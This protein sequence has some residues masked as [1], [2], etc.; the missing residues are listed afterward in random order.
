MYGRLARF[1]KKA[2]TTVKLPYITFNP[3]ILK[4]LVSSKEFGTSN[5]LVGVFV[6][7]G[8]KNCAIRIA[9]YD[10]DTG[11]K[12]TRLQLN[13][14]FTHESLTTEFVTTGYGIDT[15]YYTNVSK[16][17][18]E[19]SELFRWAHYIVIESQLP[20]NYDL[21]RM[22]Q[23]ITTYLMMTV[24]DKGFRPLII[25]IDPKLKSR[26]LGAPPKMTKPQLKVWCKNKA[27][28]ILR[29]RGDTVTADMIEKVRKGDDH[30][31]TV[32]YEEIWWMILRD[33]L[34]TPPIPQDIHLKSTKL[35]EGGTHNVGPQLLAT[36]MEL[37]DPARP[38]GSTDPIALATARLSSI[39]F[40]APDKKPSRLHIQ[41]D[42]PLP[43]VEIV[44]IVRRS[45]LLIQTTSDP[46]CPN[47]NNIPL[48]GSI[49]KDNVS[50][51]PNLQ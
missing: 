42:T 36:F 10:L 8:I 9:H 6:D 24:K 2:P 44:P 35:A 23:H 28:A 48:I 33:G 34:N 46:Q 15:I 19:Y 32:C 45:R 27:V 50:Q 3:H 40:V 4:P 22:S 41:R 26:M 51:Q 25:E 12:T 17:L 18:D 29:E 16:A 13:F 7:P 38:Q 47:E 31:D 39:P 21:V 37:H 5:F 49:L 43:V 30:G 11:A 14:D 20:I 1:N